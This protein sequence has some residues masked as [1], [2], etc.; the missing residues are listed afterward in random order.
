MGITGMTGYFEGLR[1]EG[2]MFENDGVGWEREPQNAQL[3]RDPWLECMD[4]DLTVEAPEAFSLLWLLGQVG[5]PK[6]A[7][8]LPPPFWHIPLLTSQVSPWSG[9]S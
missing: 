3:Q 1:L 5:R 8:K 7:T 2:F 4:R 9:C 6:R